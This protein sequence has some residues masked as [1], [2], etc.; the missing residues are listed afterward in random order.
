METHASQR[1]DCR[2]VYLQTQLVNAFTGKG[3]TCSGRSLFAQSYRASLVAQ[4]VKNPPVMQETHWVGKISWRRKRQPTP[5][6]LPGESQGQRS[7]EG[8]SPRGR[9]ESDVTE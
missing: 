8:C 7:L 1:L 3:L 6:F 2:D 5:V 9:K 4:P